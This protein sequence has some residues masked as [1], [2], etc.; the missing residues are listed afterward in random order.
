MRTTW[1]V[2]LAIGVA[3][4]ACAPAAA[5]VSLGIS[6]DLAPP[7]LPVY[8]QPPLPG[9]DFIWTPGYWA[10][11][12]FAAAYY[13]VPG[14]WVRAPRAG[15]LWTPPWWGW[16]GG[17]YVFHAG[18]WG[19]HVGFYGGV[20]YGFGYTGSGFQGGYW[21][22]NHVFYNQAVTNV[23][24]VH[25]TNVYRRD[26]T[27]NRL[28]RVSYN[29]GPGGVQARPNRQDW[30]TAHEPHIGATGNQQT[31]VAAARSDPRAFASTNRGRPPLAATARPLAM[32]AAQGGGHRPGAQP[33]ARVASRAQPYAVRSH[34]VRLAPVPAE[35][36]DPAAPLHA[37]RP[38]D[39][40]GARDMQR[41]MAALLPER[42]DDVDGARIPRGR[43][44]DQPNGHHDHHGQHHNASSYRPP[45]PHPS[46]PHPHASA[47]RPHSSAPHPHPSGPHHGHHR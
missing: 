15:L 21:S 28:T 39:R 16:I 1:R 33:P 6:V 13:W 31:H 44:P 9:P 2:A 11:D 30:L 10:W 34:S 7:P 47:P 24:N 32:D 36:S 38:G 20:P 29:G 23:R 35:R 12:D 46:A 5:Q 17:S 8:A 37:P 40:D 3:T 25:I 45:A 41:P 43:M 26:V 4:L 18:Y 22:G 19:P 27:V 42:I 14:T